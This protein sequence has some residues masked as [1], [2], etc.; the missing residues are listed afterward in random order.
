MKHILLYS[1]VA[2]CIL[3]CQKDIQP[4]NHNYIETAKKALRDSLGAAD[5]AA[6]DF[7]KAARSRVDSVGF[8]AFRVPF[9]GKVP[10][11]D[12]VFIKTNAKGQIENGKIVHL[13][14][15]LSDEGNGAIKRKRWD[16]SISLFS[17]NRQTVFQS[18]IVNGYITA[19]HQNASYRTTT[20]VVEG[21]MPEVVITYTIRNDNSWSWSSWFYLQSFFSNGESGG[22]GNYYSSF[23]GGSSGGDPSPGGG[24]YGGGSTSDGSNDPVILIDEENQDDKTAIDIEKFINCFNAIPDAGATCTIEIMADIPV[25]SDPNKIFDFSSKSPGHSFLNIRKKNG[26]QSV[27]QNIGFYP[28]NGWKNILTNA[29]I[30]GKFVDNGNH[31]FNAGFVQNI[32][33]EQLQ[34]VLIKMLQDKNM[35]YDIDNFNCTD[36]ALDVF[37]AAGAYQ[38]DVPRYDIPGNYPS[39]G[40]RMPSSIYI[41]VRNI[42][43]SNSAQAPNVDM[44]FL[45]AY[46]GNSTGPCN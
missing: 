8:F 7:T 6:L 40:T 30:D 11:E 32:S 39:S 1:L 16:G 33:P 27:S 43:T 34:H 45:K 2:L 15:T 21:L 10:Q 20:Q 26:T 44:D 46:A 18:S 9:R 22:G 29:P 28:K 36:W 3:S 41:T 14:G 4:S 23:I 35:K 38:L 12:F 42:K 25:D 17:L 19:Y 24:G 13:A 31:E 37:N 5:F